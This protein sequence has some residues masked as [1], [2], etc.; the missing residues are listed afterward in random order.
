MSMPMGIAVRGGMDADG[1]AGMAMAGM[2]AAA[3]SIGGAVVFIAVWTVMM[4]AMMLPAAAPMVL[5]FASAQARGGK[6][7]AVPTWIFLAGYLLVWAAVGILV[8][9]VVQ[10]GSDVSTGLATT[11]RSKWAPL[12]LGATLVVAGLYQ[13]TPLKRACLSHC[14]SP[15]AF[16]KRQPRR[17]YPAISASIP[18][19]KAIKTASKARRARNSRTGPRVQ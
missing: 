5:I 7:A 2:T 9:V 18:C 3:W 10:A 1:M 16:A 4:A 14:R 6:N 11:E 13:F 17:D 12:A 15:L 19:T 8:Y